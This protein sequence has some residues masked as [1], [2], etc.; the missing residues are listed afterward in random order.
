MATVYIAE[1]ESIRVG[2]PAMQSPPIVEQTVA[3]G[4]SS[5]ASAA[6]SSNTAYI[7]VH[8]DAICSIVI[9]LSPTATTSNMRIAANQTEYFGVTGGQQLA[10]ITNT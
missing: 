5:A 3:I 6:F 1:I 4:G 9:G 8:T 7:R 2:G 10:V